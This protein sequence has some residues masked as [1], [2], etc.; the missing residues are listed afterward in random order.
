M[1]TLACYANNASLL[2]GSFCFMHVFLFVLFKGVL[3]FIRKDFILKTWQRGDANVIQWHANT[4][5]PLSVCD[6]ATLAI[7]N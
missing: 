4:V 3:A 6:L 2:T 5:M 1:L 7:L